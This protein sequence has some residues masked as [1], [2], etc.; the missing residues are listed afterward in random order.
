MLCYNM[1]LLCIM[2]GLGNNIDTFGFDAFGRASAFKYT[3]N[4]AIFEPVF[5]LGL[6][7]AILVEEDLGRDVVL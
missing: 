3:Y 2:K 6:C 7:Q 1:S 5:L 4:I